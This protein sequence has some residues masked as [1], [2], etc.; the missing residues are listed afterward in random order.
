MRVIVCDRC[1]AEITGNPVKIYFQTVDRITGEEELDCE[2]LD[3]IDLCGAC[4][5]RI[6]EG[7][8]KSCKQP[9]KSANQSCDVASPP[10]SRTGVNRIDAGKVMALR[11]AGWNVKMIAEEMRCSEATVYNVL[12]KKKA[13][14]PDTQEGQST[15][16]SIL[17]ER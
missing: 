3:C 10:P 2:E 9:A 11:T 14:E 15:T 16:D 8:R 1:G 6:A 7:I 12:K 4:A 5:D 13:P 17:A